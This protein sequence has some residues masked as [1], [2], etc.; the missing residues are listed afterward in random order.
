MKWTFKGLFL[1]RTLVILSL[2]LFAAVVANGQG[3]V[4]VGTTTPHPS[5]QLD[6]RSTDKGV[7]IPR[8]HIT[9]T[10]VAA[11]ITYAP[12]AS[13]A[14]GLLIFNNSFVAG[15]RTSG[16]GFYYWTNSRGGRWIFLV[17]TEASNANIDSIFQQIKGKADSLTAD[18]FIKVVDRNGALAG[19]SSIL[20]F[21]KL[22]LN[23]RA[24]SDTLTNASYFIDSLIANT[25]F[26]DSLTNNVVTIIRD[27]V[28]TNQGLGDSVFV[29]VKNRADSITSQ[30]Y[31]TINGGNRQDSAV[32]AAV[33]LGL[34]MVGLAQDTL[35][36]HTLARDTSF[37]NELIRD[38]VFTTTL[39]KD[40][41]FINTLGKDTVLF[42][43]I[44][45]NGKPLQSDSLILVNGLA[46][47][48][49]AVLKNIYLK[50]NTYGLAHDT[51]FTRQLGND[52]AFISQITTNN[53]F[54][55]SIVNMITRGDTTIANYITQ[56]IRDS[57]TT[58][59]GLGDSVFVSVK[60]RADSL[61]SA[62]S[63]IQ[64]LDRN[65]NP[66][67]DSAVLKYT[68]LQLN[69]GRIIDSV[70]SVPT[71]LRANIRIVVDQSTVINDSDYTVILRGLTTDRTVT[72]PDAA[73]NKGRILV[74]NQFNGA[75]PA[76]LDAD[77]YPVPVY[78]KFVDGSNTSVKIIY[79][80]N[81]VGG[82][83]EYD[84][85]NP[86]FFAGNTGGTMKIMIQS[87]GTRWFSIGYT[88]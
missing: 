59:Q 13:P 7:L 84:Y 69:M 31:I 60:N 85:I 36:N 61:V 75:N 65:G 47:A 80:D 46:H 41:V 30:N 26:R 17:S 19:D 71:S 32:L 78:V 51:A 20:K 88:L 35:F 1:R 3:G 58:N 5:A 18:Q 68:K 42:N 52:S 34:N 2:F 57:V 9:D 64:V 56:V 33:K 27:S 55:D 40:S 53:Q 79:S 48:D 39:A 83:I 76:V 38:T 82:N 12:A 23:I 6:V 87:D 49:S 11:P 43:N 70:R 86:S 8:V 29:S 66:G 24:I 67:G 72:L 62:N 16:K 54:R 44:A 15:D 63:L 4:G 37:V 73:A 10:T 22:V 74:I 25:Q 14:E 21:A 50:L 77:G 81:G 45:A 28:T